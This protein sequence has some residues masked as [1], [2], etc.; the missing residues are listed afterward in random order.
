MRGVLPLVAVASVIAAC[1]S[2]TEGT[3]TGGC[4]DITGNWS[5]TSKV[6]SG[7]CPP[8]TNETNSVGIQKQGD[9]AYIA[10]VPG[11][12]GGCPGT[13]DAATCKFQS[14]CEVFGADGAR[15][16]ATT[17]DWTFSGKTLRG[18]EIVR[19]FPPAAPTQ[20]MSTYE[21]TGTKL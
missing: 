13:L 14:S 8:L 7:D 15:L 6:L 16:G 17:I 19:L 18:S 5:A 3:G 20:C 2:E 12:E 10:V 21:D 9:G 1:S 4:A 11:V